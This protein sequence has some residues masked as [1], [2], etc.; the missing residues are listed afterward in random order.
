MS[1]LSRNTEVITNRKNLPRE[2][3]YDVLRCGNSWVLLLQTAITFMSSDVD[4]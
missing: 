2:G 1:V 4:L 3:T